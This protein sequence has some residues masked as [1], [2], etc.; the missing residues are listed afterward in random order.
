MTDH[1]AVQAA[2]D[3]F[4]CV[5][6]LTI[7][8]SAHSRCNKFEAKTRFAMHGIRQGWADWPLNFDPVWLKACDGF[9]DEEGDRMERREADPLTELFG[10]L[11]K[12]L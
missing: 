3:C 10:M 6:R 9:S 12:R 8:G 2:P 7:P 4:V 5:H 1:K 11:G